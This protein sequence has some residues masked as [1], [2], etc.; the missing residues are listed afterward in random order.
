[1]KPDNENSL[2]EFNI[3]VVADGLLPPPIRISTNRSGVFADEI[4]TV[5]QA[6]ALGADNI[7]IRKLVVNIVEKR[8]PLTQSKQPITSKSNDK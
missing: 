4:N 3:R 6:R 1:M 7:S 2:P 5:I 8:N